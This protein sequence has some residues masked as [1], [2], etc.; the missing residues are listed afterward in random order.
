MITKLLKKAI[1][2]ILL[3]IL[4]SSLVIIGYSQ[5]KIIVKIQA[6]GSLLVPF[7][8]IEKAFE[9]ENPDIDVLVEGHGSI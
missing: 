1:L 7:G 3:F 6:A 5:E 4:I 8:A 2:G 9:A